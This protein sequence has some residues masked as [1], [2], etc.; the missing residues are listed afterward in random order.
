[1]IKVLQIELL[2]C[3]RTKSFMISFLMMFVAVTWS[4]LAASRSIGVPKLRTIGLFFNNLQ[5][6]PIFLPIAISL[7]V[8]RI[9]SN[10]KE[11]NT[12]KLQEAN[13]INLI[14]I[15][16]RKLIFT[17]TIF[18]LLNVVQVLIV[19]L[20]AVRY[21]IDVAVSNLL[22][23]VVGLTMSSFTLITFFLFLSMILEKHGMVLGIGFVSGFL[24][25]VLS[26]ASKWLNLIFPFGGSSFLA[27]Y[28]IKVLHSGDKLDYIFV[29]DKSVPL[30]YLIYLFYCIFVYF[31]IKYLL[32]KK[33]EENYD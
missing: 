29:W 17:N 18:L 22:L 26:E 8:S 11:G 31:I 32:V 6:T 4:L 10:E 2:K 19:Y 27:L 1:M 13:N 33:K 23:Q 25:M 5:A 28:R 7:F 30:N 14:T 3:K 12:F 9:V 16:K 24:G 20:Y 15:F 21:G